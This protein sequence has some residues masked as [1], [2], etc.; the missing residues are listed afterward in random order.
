MCAHPSS[1]LDQGVTSHLNYSAKALEDLTFG[2]Q[3]ATL[4]F[5]SVKHKDTPE[6]TKVWKETRKQAKK[7]NKMYGKNNI[8]I[9]KVPEGISNRLGAQL[10]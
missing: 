2:V 1:L 10:P 3:S 9:P 8:I 5:P 4:S 6:H 7:C